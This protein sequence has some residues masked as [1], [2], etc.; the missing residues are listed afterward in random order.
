MSL[1]T[2]YEVYLKSLS[3]V[4]NYPLYLDNCDYCMDDSKYEN[5][6]YGL[7]SVGTRPRL[8]QYVCANQPI[9]AGRVI[10]HEH[11]ILVLPNR[12]SDLKTAFC[13]NCYK[14]IDLMYEFKVSAYAY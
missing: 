8:G 6:D 12:R 9:A 5:E 13:I 3:L 4:K 11:P 2:A 14:V 10:L 1:T 7:Y